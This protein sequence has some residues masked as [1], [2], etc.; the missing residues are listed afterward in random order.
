[1]KN[2]MQTTETSL[3]GYELLLTAKN[4]LVEFSEG[5]A[6]LATYL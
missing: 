4:N 1:M 6:G 3:V 2:E 5:Y